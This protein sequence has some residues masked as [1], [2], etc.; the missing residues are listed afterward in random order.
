MVK[1][2]ELKS[3][4]ISFKIMSYFI[5]TDLISNL[6]FQRL[7]DPGSA[8]CTLVHTALKYLVLSCLFVNLFVK[9]HL[10][11]TYKLVAYY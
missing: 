7:V 11:G 10:V 8:L 2:T 1:K 5:Y 9:M 6:L 4:S 3:Q